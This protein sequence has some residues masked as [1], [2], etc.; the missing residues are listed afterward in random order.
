VFYIETNNCITL[1]ITRR[2]CLG[3]VIVSRGD[4]RKP[5]GI[6]LVT[7]A[8]QVLVE[9]STGFVKFTFIKMFTET[10]PPVTV[11]DTNDESAG[12]NYIV[13]PV[14]VALDLVTQEL[15]YEPGD[16][17]HQFND[18]ECVINTR[19]ARNDDNGDGGVH[20]KPSWYDDVNVSDND[21]RLTDQCVTNDQDFLH[22]NVDVTT[23]D[24]GDGDDDDDDDDDVTQYG[25]AEVYFTRRV[26]LNLN[27]NFL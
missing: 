18:I 10:V 14:N 8:S 20:V 2:F 12:V 25:D 11:V 26:S 1:Y 15:D 7:T 6:F 24:V 9:L 27:L 3:A 19:D 22:L 21:N 16:E 23:D 4:Y 17:N 5:T 13:K